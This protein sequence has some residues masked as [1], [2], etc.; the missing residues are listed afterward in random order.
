MDNE[1]RIKQKVLLSLLERNLNVASIKANTGLH[2]KTLSKY[3]KKMT[4]KGEIE[5]KNPNSK[6]GQSNFY[7]ITVKGA[8]WRVNN[9]L[10]ET[11][12]LLT[13]V[14]VRLSNPESR[15]A[16]NRTRNQH[17]LLNTKKAKNYFIERLLRGDKNFNPPEFDQTDFDQPFREALK[18]ILMLHIYLTSNSAQSPEE[19]INW[20]EKDCVLFWPNMR[21]A[22]SWHKDAFPILEHAINEADQYFRAK[23]LLLENQSE[24]KV[25]HLLGLD[26]V[27]EEYFE[28]YLKTKSAVKRRKIMKEIEDMVGWD[29]GSY[30]M[31]LF[32]GREE[33]IEKYI[34]KSKRPYLRAFIDCLCRT[35]LD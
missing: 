15:N 7:S 14:A 25:T 28:K 31:K 3:L 33:Q 10:N 26:F 4:L 21:F 18:K 24:S 23:S 29:V 1:N 35:I 19:I 5:L 22:F 2:R 6:R 17:N 34:D 32:Q 13:E 11:L 16:F 30:S 27:E 9:P 12:N 20:I 8:N